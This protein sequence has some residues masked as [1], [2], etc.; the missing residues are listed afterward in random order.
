MLALY[1]GGIVHLVSSDVSVSQRVKGSV[2]CICSFLLVVKRSRERNTLTLNLVEG[3]FAFI[4]LNRCCADHITETERPE[5]SRGTTISG[6]G[7]LIVY[8]GAAVCLF[9]LHRQCCAA[10]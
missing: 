9:V 5:S 10:L 8:Y 6:A 4:L 7:L 1:S 2:T 3:S